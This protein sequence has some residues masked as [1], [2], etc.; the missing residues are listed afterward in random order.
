[1]PDGVA[2]SEAQ[3]TG[4][5]QG[6]KEAGESEDRSVMGRIGVEPSA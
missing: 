3:A 1:M 5:A 2:V 4:R 6:V